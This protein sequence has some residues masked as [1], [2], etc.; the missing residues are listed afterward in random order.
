MTLLLLTAGAASTVTPSEE[1]NAEVDL[2]GSASAA[3]FTELVVEVSVATASTFTEPAVTVHATLQAGATHPIRVAMLWQT[4]L[5]CDCMLLTSPDKTKLSVTSTATGSARN[6]LPASSSRSSTWWS[7]ESMPV[8]APSAKRQ[9]RRGAQPFHPL[10]FAGQMPQR[11]IEFDCFRSKNQ[12]INAMLDD[13][14]KHAAIRHNARLA[15][16]HQGH[17]THSGSPHDPGLAHL[18]EP[19]PD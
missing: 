17:P 14:R 12:S 7:S 5:S 15:H 9:P 18:R 11:S 16:R 8:R 4:V 1:D 6:A 13:F 3:V 10:R 2:E 19:D